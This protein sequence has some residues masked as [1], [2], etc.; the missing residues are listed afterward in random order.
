LDVSFGPDIPHIPDVHRARICSIG[1]LRV[2][3]TVFFIE[4][5]EPVV[6]GERDGENP[7]GFW[8]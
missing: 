7:M 1:Y 4:P 3:E 5:L 8:V 2:G 6:L